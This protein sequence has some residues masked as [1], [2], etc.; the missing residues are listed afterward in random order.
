[1]R[2]HFLLLLTGA[3]AVVLV[4][5]TSQSSSAQKKTNDWGI[6]SFAKYVTIPGATRVGSEACQA[7]H[8]DVSSNFRHAF[9]AQQGIECE[10]CHG[11]GSLHVEG[12]GDVTKIVSFSKRGAR[13]ANGACLSCHAQDESVH[14]WIAG[15][16]ASNNVRCVDCHQVHNRA[17]EAANGSRLSFDTATHGALT[18]GSVSPETNVILRPMSA[19]N[20]A[21]LKCHRTEGAQL[22]MPYHHP[23]RE[24]KMSCEDCHDPHG[25]LAGNNLRTSNVN[26]LC[27]TCHAQYRGPFAYQHPPVTENCMLCHTAHGSPNTNLLSVSEPALCLQCHAGHH[28]G[29]SLPLPD[30]CTNCHPSI[31]GTDVPTPSG[32]TRF[33]DKGPSERDLLSS[34]DPAAVR[35]ASHSTISRSSM[36]ASA[37]SSVLANAVGAVGGV[38]GM[39]SSGSLLPLSGES[40]QGGTGVPSATEAGV[41][42]FSV[43]SFTPGAYRFVHGS[44]FLGRVGEYDSLQESAGTDASTAYVSTQNHL[45]VVS[46]ASVLADDDYQAASQVTVGQWAQFGFDMRSLV[47]QQDHYSFYAFPFLDV[48]PGTATPCIPNVTCVDSTTDLIPSRAVFGVRR[49]LGNAYGQ[50]KVPKLPVHLFVNGNW[51]AREG[52]TQLAYLDENT[53]PITAATPCGTQC[54]FQSQFQPVNYTTRGVGGGFDVKLHQMILTWEHSFSSFNDRLAFPIGTFTGEFTPESEGISSV[55]NP[56]NLSH[57]PADVPI[58]NYPLDIPAPNQA[59]SDRVSLDWTASPEL[60]F[61]GN[62]SYTRLRD[63]FTHYPQNS[64]DSDETLNWRPIDR[65]RLTADYHQ[66]NVINGFTP[67]YNAYGNVSYHDHSAGLRVDYELPRGFDAEVYYQRGGITRSN[68]ALWQYTQANILSIPSQ[69][70]SIDNT[71]LLKVVPSSFSNTTGMAL[72]YHSG[73]RWSARAGYEWTGTHNP[74]YLIV[75]QSNNR[76]FA[77]VTLTPAKWLIFSNDNSIIVQNAFPAIPLLRPDGNGVS[78]DFQRRNRFYFETASL[79]LPVLPE[80]NLGFGYSYQHNNL[81]TYMAFQNLPGVGYFLDEPAV[82]YKQITQAYWG[83]STY[84]IKQRLGLNLRVT[85]N[86]ARSGM[87]PD[88]N[89]ADAA[90][91]G[92]SLLISQDQFDPMGLFPSAL[93]NLEFSATQISQVI[94]PEWIGQSKGF[95]LFPHKFEGGLIFYYGSYRDYWNPNLNGVLRTFNVYVGRSW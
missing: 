65:L 58:G 60:S 16:H 11:A 70:Y 38:L 20:D 4:F 24:G 9:H 52:Q 56:L 3:V 54:H 68:A 15:P 59:S 64:F 14:N 74:G 8:S 29:A 73:D 45:T 83:E 18:A 25:G 2:R 86:S 53:V 33:V 47:Q 6:D 49:R 63:L 22:S 75:P 42:S 48:P 66:Q 91:L 95:Y 67:Y 40:M 71:D 23:L 89:P 81:T 34:G 1:M 28:D 61:N 55:N 27:L 5:L 37:P 51:Q 69:I 92:N 76:V 17:L 7:C 72:R 30:R 43:F 10:D 44:G 94:V 31:H 26:Q 36:M 12:G 46:R 88:V 41:G 35:L 39:M 13:D 77:D 50:V 85:Y 78:G 90:K 87:R 84:T 19:T 80:W 79:T 57:V 82:P 32:G 93:S 21:C 62:V